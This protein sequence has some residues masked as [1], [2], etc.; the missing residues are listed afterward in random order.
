VPFR[1]PARPEPNGLLARV[2][3]VKNVYTSLIRAYAA[4]HITNPELYT[5]AMCTLA[6][7]LFLYTTELVYYRTVRPQ[8]YTIPFLTATLGLAWM[9]AQ[10]DFYVH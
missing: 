4:Y 8:D 10:R 2:Y 5:L 6:G 3:G 9:Y 7:V 1:G